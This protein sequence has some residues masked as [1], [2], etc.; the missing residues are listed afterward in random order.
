MVA[1]LNQ[2]YDC[3]GPDLYN[4]INDVHSSI[5]RIVHRTLDIYSLYASVR[6]AIV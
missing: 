2:S 3:W 6:S 5:S 4:D 1:Q